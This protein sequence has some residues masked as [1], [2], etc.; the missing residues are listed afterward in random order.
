MTLAGASDVDRSKGPRARVTTHLEDG[1]E[2]AVVH[3]DAP[4]Q[5]VPHAL[6]LRII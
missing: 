5:H 6:H 4:Q 2:A 3:G 1:Q